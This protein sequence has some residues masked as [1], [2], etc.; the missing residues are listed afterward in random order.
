ME[1]RALELNFGMPGELSAPKLCCRCFM[2]ELELLS[3]EWIVAKEFPKSAVPRREYSCW[4]K[5]S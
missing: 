2:P 4:I 5:I 1:L 3:S